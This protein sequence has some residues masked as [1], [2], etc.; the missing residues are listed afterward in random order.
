MMRM[1]NIKLILILLKKL[2]KVRTVLFLLMFFF[3]S[4]IYSQRKVEIKIENRKLKPIDDCYV[5]ITDI[6]TNEIIEYGMPNDEGYFIFK[7]PPKI[8]EI[9]IKCQG[10]SYD[11]QTKLVNVSDKK[12][13]KINFFLSDK[14]V[15]LD[16]IVLN[17]KRK[18]I[19][20]KDT[21]IYEVSKYRKNND[22]KVIDVLER[23]PN[24]Q[25]NKKTGEIFFKGKLVEA[26]LLD[27]DDLFD[28]NYSVGTKNININIV[29]QIQAIER[30]SKNPLLKG[31]ENS[32][33]VA[34]NLVLKKGKMTFSGSIEA[35]YGLEK[36]YSAINLNSSIISITRKNKSFATNTFNNI[37]VNYS[38]F[39]YFGSSSN[40][41]QV[42]EKDFFAQKIIPE[43]R[44]SNILDSKRVNINNQY[45]GNYNA[46]FKINKRL[47]VKTNLYYL[48][49]KITN[50]RLFKNSYIINNEE[51]TTTDKTF[52]TKKPQQYR[53]DLEIKYNYSK[54]SLIEYDLRIRQ[55]DIKTPSSVV[56]NNNF[57]ALLDSK[58][59]FLKQKLLYTKKISNKKAFQFLAFQSTNNI[60]QVFK[61][62]PSVINLDN[63]VSNTQK[64]L[65]NK[66]YLETRA[67]FLGSSKKNYKYTFSIGGILD[68]N[69]LQSKLFG[70]NSF[71]SVLLENS[72]NNLEYLKKSIYQFG[73]YH[74]NIGKW[75]FSPSYSLNNLNQSIVNKYNGSKNNKNDFI[76]E[77]S[78][79]IKYKLN[80]VSFLSAKAGY[81]KTSNVERHLFLNQI[82]VNNRTTISNTPSLKLQ[83]SSN[84]GIFYYN[85]DLYNQLQINA[86]IN[87]QRTKGN[88]FTNSTINE[89]ITQINYFYL[90]Q[91]NNNISLNLLVAKYIPFLESTIKLSSNYSVS[92][93]KN[94]V[95]NSELRN[96]KGQFL[97]SKLFMKTAFDGFINFE[98]TL[99]FLKSIS[100]S[101]SSTSFS[102]E[103]LNNVFKIILRPAKKWFMLLSA[104]YFLPNRK[105]KSEN[106][107]FV[108]VS[109]RHRPKNKKIEFNFVAR[110]L[111]NK[112]NF[113]QIRT[114]DFSTILYRTN[115]L[116]RYYLLNV[117][118]NF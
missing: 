52:I 27:G 30:Y 1:L 21:V 68:K 62:N 22:I 6:D 24:V 101:N 112:D 38:P 72:T 48:N 70:E 80:S 25:V 109:I 7:I 42:K 82:L 65:S 3:L 55:E 76:F 53:G 39:N 63:Y 35:G 4:N 99:N 88:F 2:N 117:T 58:D 14:L 19:V 67:V 31:I 47:K 93:Y 102:N 29:K 98:N 9:K 114:T 75:K 113:E 40:L 86:G 111:L 46:I 28:Y 90:P 78:L 96:N 73:S 69:K 85:N 106:Y 59:Y 79:Y 92:K 33:K 100:E 71:E 15:K 49:D 94:I 36:S 54:T 51:F 103:S 32:D 108:D 64:A 45:F 107:T 115:I 61:I 34:I 43:T 12:L 77:P 89:N 13:Y 60:S 5:I 81:N 56:S 91:N 16:E 50:T 118:Y 83:E 44:F 95:N 41:E 57:E 37:G 105:N 23:L 84:Y 97:E 26:L 104:D 110:N 10:L 8:K 116:P 11:A 74:L 20:K 66:N 87:Y 18:I 17:S